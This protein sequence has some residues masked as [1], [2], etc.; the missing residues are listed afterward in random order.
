MRDVKARIRAS[1]KKMMDVDAI[2][3]DR[4]PLGDLVAEDFYA[5]G[6]DPESV[7]LVPSEASAE[8]VEE[9]EPTKATFDFVADVKGKGKEVEIDIDTLMSKDTSAPKAALLEPI[10]KAEDGFALWES[11]S[12][13]GDA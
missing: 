4:A 3:V 1:R 5:E 10:E 8:D 11:G 2:D 12:D 13:K 9:E 7:F 6:C